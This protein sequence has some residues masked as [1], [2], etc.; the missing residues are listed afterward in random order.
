MRLT[1]VGEPGSTRCEVG[2]EG[3]W[4]WS[5]KMTKPKDFMRPERKPCRFYLLIHNDEFRERNYRTREGLTPASP[6]YPTHLTRV[7]HGNLSKVIGRVSKQ[8]PLRKKKR[9]IRR[10]VWDK[11][12]QD[13]KWDSWGK[14]VLRSCNPKETNSSYW[15]YWDCIAVIC[16][17]GFI[18]SQKLCITFR[19]LQPRASPAWRQATRSQLSSLCD[20]FMQ[21]DREQWWPWDVTAPSSGWWWQRVHAVLLLQAFLFPC[22]FTDSNLG[23]QQTGAGFNGSRGGFGLEIENTENGEELRCERA[24]MFWE[25]GQSLLSHWLLRGKM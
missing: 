13:A 17:R 12:K 20:G 15:D 21:E 3:W 18:G 5:W 2:L 24:L 9:K 6:L 25:K 14:E 10:I 11:S 16:L 23:M 1:C 4:G 7:G 19:L 8:G 22:S